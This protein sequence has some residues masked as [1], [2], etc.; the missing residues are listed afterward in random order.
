MEPTS[1][2]FRLS[3]TTVILLLFT[4]GCGGDSSSLPMPSPP[5]VVTP[6][7]ID[8]ASFTLS[9]GMTRFYGSASTGRF[10]VPVA[11]GFDCDGDGNQDFAMS[12]MQASPFNRSG[13]GQV[14]LVFGNANIGQEIDSAQPDPDTVV[15]AGAASQE[16]A[17][18]EIWMDD[19]TGDGIGDLIIGRHNYRNQSPDRVGAGAL[20]VVVGAAALRNFGG[21]I[22]DLAMPPLELNILTVTGAETLDRLG[23]WMRTGD[24]SG[25]GI[26]DIV[27]G[28]D[29]ADV[30]GVSNSGIAYVLRG[31]SQ[32]DTTTQVDLAA[33]GGSV[34]DGHIARI[35]PPSISNDYHFGAT[36]AIADLDGN[37]RGE[38]LVAAAL[39][40]VGGLLVADGAPQDSAIRNG[41]NFGGSLF[42]VWDD[43]L[44]QTNPWPTGLTVDVENPTGALTR[45]D[46]GEMA[47]VFANE[48]FG[49]EI[50]GGQ[51][52]DADGSVDLFVGDIRGDALPDR[53]EAGLGHVFF[54][55]ELLKNRQFSVD[56]LPSD[57]RV[58]TILGES[59]G[60]ISSDTSMHGDLDGDGFVDLVI[61]SPLASPNDR[62]DAGAV[63][64]LWG[65]PGPWP[66]F[67][68]LQARPDPSEFLIS[69][70]YGARGRVGDSDQGDTLMYSAAAGDVDGDGQI[71]LVVNEMRGNGAGAGTLDVGNL[72]VISGAAIPKRP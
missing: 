63:H 44:P 46:G 22:V 17:G 59:A 33:I 28:A 51:D 62:V 71:D 54:T 57:L 4:Q 58:T 39:S 20:T 8:L 52:Y 61:A 6:P 48:R 70:I 67:I 26:S 3:F 32:L 36:V 60:A 18:G 53:V 21:A 23:F 11:A 25:D 68:D 19:V 41:G 14:W 15:F 2:L 55:A 12:G 16:S 69:D 37:N 65:Q 47:N 31:G 35:L 42:I 24:V 5:P 56:A 27:F 43:N 13:A 7:I 50:L 45:I 9:D 1:N 64:V 38:I 10:G 29:Q 49:E 40:R 30:N 72:L 66:D 34:L